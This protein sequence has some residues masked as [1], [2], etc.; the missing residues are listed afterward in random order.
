VLAVD[1]APLHAAESSLGR[2]AEVRTTAT[3]KIKPSAIFEFASAF[4]SAHKVAN[5]QDGEAAMLSGGQ[6]T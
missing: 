3:L 5:E 2:C 4:T 1:N 6:P